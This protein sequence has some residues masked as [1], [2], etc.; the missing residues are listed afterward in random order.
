MIMDVNKVVVSCNQEWSLRF[1]VSVIICT[2]VFLS[3]QWDL[4]MFNELL[5]NK[6]LGMTNDITELLYGTRYLVGDAVLQAPFRNDFL[7]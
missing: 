1:S 5:Y 6:A 3:V 2:S 7:H 4:Y